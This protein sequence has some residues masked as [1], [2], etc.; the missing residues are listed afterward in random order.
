MTCFVQGE[1]SANIRINPKGRAENVTFSI[2]RSVL[3]LFL[4]GRKYAKGGRCGAVL[5]HH[6]A[7]VLVCAMFK[8]ANFICFFFFL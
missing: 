8:Y 4:L 1:L 2:I 5:S 3:L 7:G 6:R